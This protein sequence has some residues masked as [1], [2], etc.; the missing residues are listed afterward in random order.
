MS[1]KGVVNTVHDGQRVQLCVRHLQ[2]L[3]QGPRRGVPQDG[4]RTDEGHAS[5]LVEDAAGPSNADSSQSR[6]SQVRIY[7]ALL[8]DGWMY[9]QSSEFKTSL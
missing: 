7:N 3:L 9:D 4:G 8:Y 5:V 2:R 1:G 6:R